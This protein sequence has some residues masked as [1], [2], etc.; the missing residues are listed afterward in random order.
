MFKEILVPFDGSEQAQ[1]ALAL[2]VGFYEDDPQVNIHILNLIEP[3]EHALMRNGDSGVEGMVMSQNQYM[4]WRQGLIEDAQEQ[5]HKELANTPASKV[6]S[7]HLSIEVLPQ[8]PFADAIVESAQE[9]HCDVI[10]MGSR[11]LGALRGILGSVSYGVLR[12]SKLPVLI[13]K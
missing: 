3:P 6:K 2:A 10:V 13:A 1:R 11:G 9:H 4:E 7:T 8:T 12:A 5:L